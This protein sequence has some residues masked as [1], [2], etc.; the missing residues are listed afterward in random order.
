[1]HHMKTRIAVVA[2]LLVLTACGGG[3]DEGSSTTSGSSSSSSAGAEGFWVSGNSGLLVTSTGEAWLISLTS[4]QYS[5]A[6]GQIKASGS[7]I[8]GSFST[9]VGTPPSF[10]VSGTVT[11]KSSM[12]LTA[13]AAGI[14]PQTGVLSYS[15]A[16]DGTPSVAGLAGSYVISS[17]GAATISSTGA[18]STGVLSNGCVASG[19][20]TPDGSGKNFYRAVL[21]YSNVLVGGGIAG[22]V[23]D[24]FTL[25]RL[26]AG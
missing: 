10:V 17:G 15:S 4:P 16:Y 3:G 18:F 14:S 5:L 2:T 22:S 24:A 23:G 7:A 12:T 6:K 9:Y 1:M 8:S 25:T 20:I 19:Q 11:S 26:T 13:T 21:S